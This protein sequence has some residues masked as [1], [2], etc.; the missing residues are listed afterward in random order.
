MLTGPFWDTSNA[1][2]CYIGNAGGDIQLSLK[3]GPPSGLF[4]TL[5][6]DIT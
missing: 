6:N 1:A 2:G 3:A 5:K 4:A